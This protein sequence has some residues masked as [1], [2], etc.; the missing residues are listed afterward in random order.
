[1]NNKKAS[2]P[3]KQPFQTFL[4]LLHST[5]HLLPSPEI[6]PPTTF[7]PPLLTTKNSPV[8]T[9][10]RQDDFL[11]LLVEVTA[12]KEPQPD[13]NLHHQVCPSEKNFSL[14]L[15]PNP[16][17]HLIHLL[18]PNPLQHLIHLLLPPLLLH[19][20]QHL[21]LGVI[22]SYSTSCPNSCTAS[23]TPC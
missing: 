6:P 16:L 7:S 12:T 3:R 15:L 4:S 21:P 8:H 20:V 13:R 22:H 10:T 2:D 5:L 14:L 11:Q 18:L 1:M 23:T 9:P 19:Q 17:Q